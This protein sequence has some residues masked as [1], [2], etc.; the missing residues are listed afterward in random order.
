MEKWIGDALV[1]PI[2]LTSDEWDRLPV[3]VITLAS[4]LT[5]DKSALA[6]VGS[7]ALNEM[8][9]FLINKRKMLH[10]RMLEGVVRQLGI[11][12]HAGLFQDAGAVGADGAHAEGKHPRNF[13]DGF[14]R[15]DHA[16]DLEFAV[17]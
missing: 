12:F 10:Q 8:R 6:R 2:F 9:A 14:A 3:G 15:G 1:L 13:A 11:R 16:H 7:Q 5:K 17:G 4:T